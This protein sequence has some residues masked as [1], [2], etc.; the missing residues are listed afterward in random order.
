MI[1]NGSGLSRNERI[2]ARHMGQLLLTA[3]Q[4][5]VM[6]EFISSLPIAAVD[7][8]M[9]KRLNGSA[10]AGQAHIK[11][12][13]LEGVRTMAGYVLNRSGKRIVSCIFRQSPKGRKC[14]NRN[15]Y[16]VAADL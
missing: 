4:S 9:K 6:P 13:L 14:P 8:T 10:I 2:S 5:P 3:F 15:G 11:T 7:G 1:E 12:G 16:P